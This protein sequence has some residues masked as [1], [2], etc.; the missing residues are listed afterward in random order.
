[1]KKLQTGQ[2][3]QADELLQ[4]PT[5]FGQLSFLSDPLIFSR[6]LVQVI[7]MHLSFA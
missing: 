1:M 6:I 3:V 7:F 5:G 4:L 2:I